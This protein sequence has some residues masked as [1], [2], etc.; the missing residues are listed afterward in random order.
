[1]PPW[2]TRPYNIFR[3]QFRALKKIARIDDRLQ[4]RIARRGHQIAEQKPQ[5]ELPPALLQQKK[6]T[7]DYMWNCASLASVPGEEFS[8]AWVGWHFRLARIDLVLPGALAKLEQ[9]LR[10]VREVQSRLEKLERTPA[11]EA[12]RSALIMASATQQ[13]IVEAKTSTPQ[14]NMGFED[15]GR[16][17]QSQKV[18]DAVLEAVRSVESSLGVLIALQDTYESM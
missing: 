18:T 15:S 5:R 11:F 6:L 17:P 16:H 3:A 1:M 13:P 9:L 7:L 8:W 14:I 12:V 2:G 10:D 4:E